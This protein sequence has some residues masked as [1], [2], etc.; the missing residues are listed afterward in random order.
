M[1]TI[2]AVFEGGGVRGI[3]H[4][5]AIQATEEKYDLKAPQ[6]YGNVAGTSAGA[7]IASLLACDYDGDELETLMRNT[8]YS[9]FAD[10]S[11]EQK[12]PFIGA[13]LGIVFEKGM[14]KGEYLLHW[15]NARY[16]KNRGASASE[17]T[18][19]E[20]KNEDGSYRLQVVASDITR[21]KMII[22]PRDIVA[23][24]G[25]NTP[26][27]LPVALAVRM[28]AS[29]PFYFDPIKLKLKATGQDCFI[30]DGGLLSD[31]PLEIVNN[32][33]QCTLGYRLV[34]PTDGKPEKI[35]GP[36]DMLEALFNTMLT[37]HDNLYIE[38]HKFRNTIAIETFGTIG[39]QP[40]VIEG[41]DF[42]ISPAE[43]NLLHGNGRKAAQKFFSNWNISKCKPIEPQDPNAPNASRR[44]HL[45][46]SYPQG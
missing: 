33:E 30:V 5:G 10:N 6:L 7:V 11:W 40:V 3:G 43:L 25:Y 9:C 23:Y 38:D 46:V 26:D 41:T 14:H 44:A 45:A 18:F 31:Y 2:N 17:F 36:V 19:K 16:A 22:L 1:S 12:M 39:N 13:V 32:G 37:A 35:V 27:D 34:G 29:I 8:N 15:L 42:G 20:L 21:G 24:E 28:S 4:V